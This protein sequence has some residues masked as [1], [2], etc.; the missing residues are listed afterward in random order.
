MKRQLRPGRGSSIEG[1]EVAN[2]TELERYHQREHQRILDEG[3]KALPFLIDLQRLQREARQE[4]RVQRFITGL[5][6]G[7]IAFLTMRACGF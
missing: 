5:F 1:R 7:G 4:L 6:W 2:M 3:A